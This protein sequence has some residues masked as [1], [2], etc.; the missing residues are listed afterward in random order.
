MR[1]STSLDSLVDSHINSS[2]FSQHQLGN[3]LEIVVSYPITTMQFVR[4]Q[5]LM[6]QLLLTQTVWWFPRLAL[7]LHQH[8]PHCLGAEPSVLH[9][10]PDRHHAMLSAQHPAASSSSSCASFWSGCWILP[11]LGANYRHMVTPNWSAGQDLRLMG[12]G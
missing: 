2:A 5:G 10:D 3:M 9:L 4:N 8:L 12:L 7:Q 6:L 11:G 1:L